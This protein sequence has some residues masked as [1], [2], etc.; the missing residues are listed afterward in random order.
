M[1]NKIYSSLC[2]EKD[3]DTKCNNG[4]FILINV[5]TNLAIF[6]FDCY[7]KS[8]LK[9]LKNYLDIRKNFL[10]LY[11]ILFILSQAAEKL[12]FTCCLS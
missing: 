3:N 10:H 11:L 12:L 7:H 8:I 9:N 1:L 5:I 6:N 4:R 2:I